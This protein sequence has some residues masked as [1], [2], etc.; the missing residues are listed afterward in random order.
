MQNP[1]PIT[2]C[3]VDTCVGRVHAKGM[4]QGHYRRNAKHGTPLIGRPLASMVP[5]GQAW[6]SHCETLKP[7]SEF[8]KANDRPSGTASYCRV[9]TMNLR[10]TR[11]RSTIYAQQKRWRDAN[12]G[13]AT[14][15]SR[16][17][18]DRNPE[19]R[20]ALR[21]RLL[22]A[23]PALYARSARASDAA[24]RAREK[25]A[26]GVATTEQIAARWDYYG[27]KCW[28]CGAA[29]T[30]ID[31]VK[32]LAKGGSHWPANLR[33]ACR[34]CNS[35]KRAQWPYPLEVGKHGHPSAIQEVA[36]GPLEP[37]TIDRGVRGRGAIRED[38]H[39]TD[40]LGAIHP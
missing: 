23:N 40:R 27:G 36:A 33:P 39:D 14:E 25:G 35:K 21:A 26:P 9:C 18:A 30:E 31:H 10:A 6:C 37:V 4:C 34:S 5:A 1:T 15:Y 12:P 3:S 24:R 7:T 16:R 8:P 2:E 19:K 13:K 11:Y 29:A 17:Y 20:A 22:A 28:M 32:P 38:D